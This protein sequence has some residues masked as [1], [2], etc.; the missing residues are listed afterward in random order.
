MNTSAVYEI[1]WKN[2]VQLD[3]PQMI[4]KYGACAL[5]AGW[6]EQEYLQLLHCRNIYTNAPRCYGSFYVLRLSFQLTHELVLPP[7]T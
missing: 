4:I 1:R 7:F 2:M 3:R 5:H 6:L